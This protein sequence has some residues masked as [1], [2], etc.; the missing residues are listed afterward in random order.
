MERLQF[1]RH[2]GKTLVGEIDAKNRL[3][4]QVTPQGETGKTRAHSTH[5]QAES[6]LFSIARESGFTRVK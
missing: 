1:G 3:T 2:D 4:W 6:V 5:Q